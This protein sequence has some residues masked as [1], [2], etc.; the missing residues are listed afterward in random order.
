VTAAFPAHGIGGRQDL[1][2]PFSYVVI[3]A[4]V[5]LLLSFLVLGLLWREPRLREDDD[6][7][8]G[9]LRPGGRATWWLR[10]VGLVVAG[11][12]CLALLAGPDTAENPAAG[13][14]FV[15]FWVGLLVVSLLLGPVWRALNPL[16][17]LHLAVM[18]AL[19]R[20]PDR[21]LRPLP[22]RLGYHPAAVGLLAFVW[23]ELVAPQRSTSAVLGAWLAGYA[24]VM[25]AGATVY[26]ARWFDRGDAFEVYSDLAGRLAPVC[27]DGAGRLRSRNPING[28]AGLP[29]A[30]G[31]PLV[32]I[33]LLGS[34]MY[35]SMSNA[36]QW[37]QL[38]Q[39]GPLPPAVLGT[40]GL[41]GVIG[42][43]LGA[44]LA[45]TAVAA[46]LGAGAGSTPDRRAPRA[47][48]GASGGASAR[49][50]AGELAASIVPIA[51]GYLLAHYGTLLILEG[52]RT[53]AL[54]SD[55]LDT[56]ADWLGTARWQVSALGMSPAQVALTQVTVIVLGHLFGTVLA[57]DRALELFARAAA[58]RGQLPLLIL[59]VVF[60][61]TGLLLL[62]A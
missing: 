48:S 54:L 15:L 11:W 37:V 39:S 29:A 60:T 5:A 32:V 45:A 62:F 34:T 25:L 43:A 47:R 38:V 28:M 24:I 17:A 23:L 16:R 44:Y 56:G 22:S 53:I 9:L 10:G 2:I 14:V 26:G 61:V 46:R 7:T 19:R 52:Q 51:V 13:M 41:L 57:H 58:V 12:L 55:P 42:V 21:G 30:P 36:P 8:P 40:L 6:G 31:L 4:A 20:D 49:L 35:D 3:G 18:T 50:V 27:R 1:P 33:V 59:M